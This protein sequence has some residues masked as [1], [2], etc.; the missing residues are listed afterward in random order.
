M[1]VCH[2]APSLLMNADNQNFNAPIRLTHGDLQGEP[3]H[4]TGHFGILLH[5][6][7]AVQHIPIIAPDVTRITGITGP[8][9]GSNIP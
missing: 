3:I 8:A 7:A 9:R 4:L 1:K 2:N 6:R 5:Q